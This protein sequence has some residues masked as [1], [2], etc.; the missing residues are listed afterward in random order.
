MREMTTE[1]KDEKQEKNG[2]K[3]A[4]AALRIGLLCLAVWLLGWKPA[5]E[6]S[7]AFLDVGQGDCILVRTSSGQNYLFDCGST[8]R[9]G[10]GK[11][12]LI[13]YLKY[14]GIRELDGLFLSHP[15]ADHI[16]GALE[17]LE[18]G[19]ENQITIRQMILPA[20]E[21]KAG[22]EQLGELLEAA[23]SASQDSP[24]AVGFLA[25]GEGWDCGGAVFTCLHPARGYG[26]E[27]VNAYSE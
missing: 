20:I 1:T 27:N 3:G 2:R 24:V 12:V 15:D 5:P 22:E 8:S 13:P 19:G 9:S 14:Y 16:N 4:G 6:N 11:Y 23:G 25:A 18:T 7:V 26:G 17:L 21:E 10:V